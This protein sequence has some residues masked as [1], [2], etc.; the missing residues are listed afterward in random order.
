MNT[1]STAFFAYEEKFRL[2]VEGAAMAS[3]VFATPFTSKNIYDK[4]SRRKTS[5]LVCIKQNAGIYMWTIYLE[6]DHT[7]HPL[8]ERAFDIWT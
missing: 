6:F 4:I 5:F 8:L 7:Y 2:L 1:V 3:G